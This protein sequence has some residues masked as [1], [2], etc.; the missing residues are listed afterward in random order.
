MKCKEIKLFIVFVFLFIQACSTKKQISSSVPLGIIETTEII[1]NTKRAEVKFDNLRN[2]VKVDYNDG[3]SIQTVIL[4]LRASE[5]EN[6]W[7]SASMIVPIAKVFITNERIVF[8]EKFQKTYINQEIDK[9]MR[10]AGIKRPVEILQNLLFGRP[11]SDINKGDWDRIENSNYYVL[12][13]KSGIQNTVFINPESFQLQQQRVYLPLISSL[14]TIDYG[15]FKRIDENL[16]PT[17]VR[18]T[19][20]RGSDV[21][22]INLEYSQYDFPD[23]LTFPMDIPEGYKLKTLD[24]IIK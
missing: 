20:M 11:L 1:K 7:I 8:Y 13:S 19:S 17:S 16:V 6:L 10:A 18:I 9:I 3:K 5:D 14:L 12:Q 21:I 2:R 22:S 23:N 24:E 15:N 4:S